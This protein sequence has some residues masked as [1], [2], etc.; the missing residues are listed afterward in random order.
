LFCNLID[1]VEV[2]WRSW[3]SNVILQQITH[4]VIIHYVEISTVGRSTMY[5]IYQNLDNLYLL[6]SNWKRL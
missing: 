4:I 5:C 2:S 1:V 3:D 6:Y